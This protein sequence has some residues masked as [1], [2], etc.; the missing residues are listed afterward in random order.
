MARIPSS[1]STT[2]AA[3]EVARRQILWPNLNEGALWNRRVNDGF[4]TLP[5]TMGLIIAIINDLTKGKP[6]GMAYLELWCRARD[7]MFTTL[8]HKDSIA[9]HSGYTG[10]RAVR[11]W[12]DRMQSLQRLE[13]VDIKPGSSGP[14]TY[15]LIWNPYHVIRRLYETPTPGLTEDKYNALIDRCAEIGADDWLT[16]DLPPKYVISSKEATPVKRRKS[17]RQERP[18]KERRS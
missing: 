15:A 13:F 5:R 8:A 3:K 6:A 11:T 10:A 1:R 14:L 18:Q 4:T 12:S 17:A 7:S 9:F 16:A 2:F